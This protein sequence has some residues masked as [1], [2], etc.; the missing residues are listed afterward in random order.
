MAS[1]KPFSRSAT[2]NPS[3]F[4]GLWPA[5]S[6]R[7]PGTKGPVRGCDGVQYYICSYGG[8][9]NNEFYRRDH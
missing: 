9:K 5:L 6:K 8:R 2:I 1:V 3:F 7:E 4:I